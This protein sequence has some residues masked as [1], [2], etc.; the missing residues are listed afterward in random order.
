MNRDQ[1]EAYKKEIAELYSSRSQS[2][3]KSEWH[4]QMARKLVDFANIKSDSQVLDIGTGTGMVALYAASK[5][6]AGGSV[7]GI[8]ISEGMIE[9]AKSKLDASQ[10]TTVRFEL[11]DGESLCF[12]PNSF[13]CIF[14]GSAFIWMTDLYATLTHWKTFLK[15]TGKIGFHAFSENAFIT[16]VVA[17]S[18][19][20]DYGVDYLMNKPT[21]TVDKCFKLLEQ[22]GYK[23]IDVKL[24]KGG[25]YISLEEARRSW[26]SMS[27]PA[28]GQFPHPLAVL[29]PEQL[30][31]ARA[32]Y[33]QEIEKLNTKDGVWNDMTTFFVYGER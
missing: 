26:V 10:V 12:A 33:E 9:K 19:L 2:Y 15:P 8:D 29:T 16:G 28:P 31:C 14:C 22:S 5:L 27:H 20:L 32:D 24:D 7:I 23:N 11:G 18:V 21:G 30:A 1:A 3:D 13:D 4:D 25:N 6:V 17:Q